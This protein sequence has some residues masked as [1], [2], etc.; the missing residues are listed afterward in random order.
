ME[1]EDAYLEKRIKRHQDQIRGLQYTL[2]ALLRIKKRLERQE[3]KPSFQI[4]QL[5][6]FDQNICQ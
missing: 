2:L 1:I 3:I 5:N 4:K 6:F